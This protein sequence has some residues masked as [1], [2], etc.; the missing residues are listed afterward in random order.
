MKTWANKSASGKGEI[1]SL[2]HAARAWPALPERFR[3]G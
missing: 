1:T 2:F 3:W